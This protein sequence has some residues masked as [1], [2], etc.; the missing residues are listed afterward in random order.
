MKKKIMGILIC[1]LFILTAFLPLVATKNIE[2]LEEPHKLDVA[3][4]NQDQQDGFEFLWQDFQLAQSFKPSLPKLT[5]ILLYLFRLGQDEST[6]TFSIREN[7]DGPDLISKSISSN[8]IKPEKEW[9]WVELDFDDIKVN[10]ESTY[11]IVVISNDNDPYMEYSAWGWHGG[12]SY[13]RGSAYKRYLLEPWEEF[14]DTDFCFKT[15]GTSPRS[16]EYNNIL[17]KFPILY[18]LFQKLIDKIQNLKKIF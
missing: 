18:Q 1:M 17:E 15:Y 6:I 10:P 7:L 8:D 14:L 13:S 12:D 2:K 5:R 16:R 4:Q 9:V 11:Y 3:D